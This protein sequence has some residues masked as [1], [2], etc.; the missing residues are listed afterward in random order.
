[1]N[2]EEKKEKKGRGGARI[3]AG[4]PKKYVAESEKKR[5]RALY[6]TSRELDILREALK[7][8]RLGNDNKTLWSCRVAEDKDIKER[9]DRRKRGQEA[10][11]RGMEKEKNKKD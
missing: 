4:R 5:M 11:K 2:E 1:M 9:V 3:G 8:L 7:Q 10:W 6:C